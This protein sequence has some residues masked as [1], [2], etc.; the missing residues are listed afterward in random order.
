MENYKLYQSKLIQNYHKDFINQCNFINNT[1]KEKYRVRD[2]TWEYQSYNVFCI[3]STSILFYQL[4]KELNS[5]IREFVGNK[6][7]LWIQ[8]WLNYHKDEDAEKKLQM[9][10]HSGAYHGYISID[11]QDTTTI[12]RNG[13]QIN[14][15]PGQIYLG[16][17]YNVTDGIFPTSHPW[18]HAVKINKPYKGNRITIGFDLCEVQNLELS[19]SFI[20]LL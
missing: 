17:G 18:D 19:P 9:H 20:P 11:P 2:T 3:T 8:A 6:K 14:N 12:F 10:G 5:Y 7:P 13:L 4:Y 16:P 1:L 15:K